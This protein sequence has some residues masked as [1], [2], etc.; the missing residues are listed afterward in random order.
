[1]IKYLHDKQ[2]ILDFLSMMGI[3]VGD[4]PINNLEKNQIDEFNRVFWD[5]PDNTTVMAVMDNNQADFS[6]KSFK[7]LKD[8]HHVDCLEDLESSFTDSTFIEKEAG[9]YFMQCFNEMLLKHSE[10]H[11][12]ECLKEPTIQD[13][14]PSGGDPSSLLPDFTIR[15]FKDDGNVLKERLINGKK[16]CPYNL[17]DP[18][19]PS[20]SW[21]NKFGS[22]TSLR[23]LKIGKSTDDH[24]FLESLE[25]LYNTFKTDTRLKIFKTLDQALHAKY[26]TLETRGKM[27]HKFSDF[28]IVVLD[29]FHHQWCLLKCLFSAY[30]DAGLKDLVAILGVDEKKWPNMLGESKNVHKAQETLVVIATSFGVFFLNY[31]LN[32]ITAEQRTEYETK[33]LSEKVKW[34]SHQLPSFLDKVALTDKTLAIFIELY[35]F[36]L[37]VIQCW[38]SQRVAN[39][40]M[41]I[42]SIKETLPYILCFNRYNY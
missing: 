18:M 32:H 26:K 8:S 5:I 35:K 7:P 29:P 17:Y 4:D 34:I 41:Y 42:H 10:L 9:S 2:K 3:G 33:A 15:F 39:Y 27:P 24:V 25:F 1:M 14:I 13:I 28:F 16:Y 6:T 21:D 31:Y 12:T 22:K 19:D 40:D 11:P 23:F 37:L 38:E 36:S 20:I 30:E